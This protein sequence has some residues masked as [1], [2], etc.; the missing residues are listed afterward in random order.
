MIAVWF[1]FRAF[2]GDG[3]TDLAVFTA[4]TAGIL[5]GA[6]IGISTMWGHR[7]L[8]VADRVQAIEY[9][10]EIFEMT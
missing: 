2:V 9:F 10:K 8:G 1:G 5:S 3:S 7:L 6:V 4:L